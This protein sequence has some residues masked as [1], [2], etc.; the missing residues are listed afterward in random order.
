MK[1]GGKVCLVLL[2]LV[3][4]FAGG[5]YV[6][7]N[8]QLID[9]AEEGGLPGPGSA[10]STNADNLRIMRNIEAM[11]KV[12][13][14]DFIFD[15]TD[16][17][18]EVGIYKG[19]FSGLHD[20]YSVFYTQE[21]F[22]ALMEETSGHFAG[23]GLEITIGEDNL[24][25][26]VSPIEGSPAA[27]AGI[28]S[29]DKIVEIDGEAYLGSQLQEAAKAMRGEPGSKVKVT[30]R[31]GTKDKEVELTR[32]EINKVSVQTQMLDDGVGYLNIVE[33]G[34]QTDKDFVA[35]VKK[36][37]DQGMQRMVLDLRNNPGGVL[38]SVVSICDRLLPEGVI[39]STQD[40]AGQEEK[41]TSDADCYKM[42][43]VVLVNEGS[44]SASEILTGALR[45]HNRALIVGKTTFGKGIVQ[46]IYPLSAEGIQGGI[47]LTMA[48]Y[49]TPN[50]EHINKK[51]IKPDIVVEIPD[52]V[53]TIG[54]A[55]LSKDTQLLRAIAEVKKLEGIEVDR[56]AIQRAGSSE[57]SSEASQASSASDLREEKASEEGS[58]Q[59][60]SQSAE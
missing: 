27:E 59:E 28:R 38:D 53:E 16:E 23:V 33:F 39:V 17:D 15:Y 41:F 45:D 11:K 51:G 2:L 57:E 26:V 43:I 3:A 56:A 25:T 6:G 30:F 47:K 46:R 52:G 34:D 13:N 8:A 58:S 36:L 50:G 40:K 5:F 49:L 48:E 22:N 12:I 19:L 24:I 1:K 29:G 60:A 37:Q 35:A 10:Q 42:P 31:R 54:P 9:V 21:E 20:P 14:Q 4:C 55:N 7:N 18:L 44:A 32:A